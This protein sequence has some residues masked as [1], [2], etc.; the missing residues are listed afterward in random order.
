M[1]ENGDKRQEQR[2][3]RG[4]EREREGERDREL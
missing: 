3:Q 4:G 2:A 1:K